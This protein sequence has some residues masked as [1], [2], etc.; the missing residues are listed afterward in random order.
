ME[1]RPL[2]AEDLSALHIYIQQCP[3]RISDFSLGFLLMW[4]PYAHTA[5]AEV[6]GCLLLRSEYGGKVRFLYPLHPNA[7]Q[8][9]E[10]RALEALERW[11]VENDT[12]LALTTIPLERLPFLTQRYGR[13]LTLTNPRT[14]R[15]YLYHYSDFVEYAGKR[16][17]GQRNHV[18]K[19][20]RAYPNATF[21]LMQEAD[22]DAVRAFLK[23]YAERQFAKHSFIA[24]EELYGSEQLLN[25]FS[26]LHQL[27]GML[28]VGETLVAITIGEIMGDT[29]VVHVEKALVEFDGAYPTI[30]HLFAQACQREGLLYINRED[31][32]G[33]CGLRKSKLQYNPVKLL[34][35]YTL[36]PRRVIESIEKIPEIRS[37]RLV[38]R[39]VSR[40]EQEVHAYGRL[41]RNLERNRLWGWDW[42]TL[43]TEEGEPR[44]TWFLDVVLRDFENH[45]EV[46]LGIFVGDELVGEG[47]FHNFTYDHTVEL[48]IRLLPE[49][50]HH[51]YAT[52]ALKVMADYALCFWGLE[53]VFAKSY[54]DNLASQRVLQAS[55]L[56]PSHKDETFT[57]F[58]RTAKN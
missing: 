26:S 9:A 38:L 58:M 2:R 54:H 29:L 3:F 45:N 56:R 44:D 52:E 55:G 33:D 30:A 13:D 4:L 5:M 48:G 11:C 10:C 15:D 8:E 6:E 12:H 28:F 49:H 43:W 41:A 57:Y 47:V 34:D 20:R 40:Q 19:F 35:K 24:N 16:F 31:D 27:G 37:E 32:A 1:F 22:L 50:E 53:K 39:E 17:S 7:D 23:V 36:I 25:A 14:W 21:R 42:R 51:G 46:P 18:S